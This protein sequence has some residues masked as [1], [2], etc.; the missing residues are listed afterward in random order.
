[1]ISKWDLQKQDP[2]AEYSKPIKPIVFWIEN[3][4]PL[5][6]RDYIKDGVLAWNIAFKEAGFIDAIEVKIQPDDAKWD[7]GDIRYNVLQMGLLHQTLYL[8]AM[9]QGLRILELVKL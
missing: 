9:G 6:L 7:A 5:E 3:T 8:E 4:T 1:M 2:S